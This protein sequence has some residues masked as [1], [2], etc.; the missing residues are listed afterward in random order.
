VRTDSSRLTLGMRLEPPLIAFAGLLT[1]F[2]ATT[3]LQ[4]IEFRK[5]F[6]LRPL[7]SEAFH[8]IAL[9]RKS[10]TTT[11]T[12]RVQCRAKPEE[13]GCPWDLPLTGRR[14][15]HC[16]RDYDLSQRLYPGEALSLEFL[17]WFAG[18]HRRV[19]SFTGRCLTPDCYFS[20]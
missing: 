13:S 4:L 7:T 3:H 20:I 18:G 15:I 11:V 1:C 8:V 12:K 2:V 6:Q 17:D 9:S 5:M 14:S 19:L 10:F 16:F